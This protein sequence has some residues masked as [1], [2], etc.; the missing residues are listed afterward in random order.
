MGEGHGFTDTINPVCACRTEV[1]TTEHFLLQCHFYCTVRL[2]LFENIGKIDPN[3]L[4]LNEKGQVIVL[5]HS[6][7]I[8]KPKSFNQNTLKNIMSLVSFKQ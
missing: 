1:E 4:N 2:E 5:L 8:D 6:Y 3:F 7:Q